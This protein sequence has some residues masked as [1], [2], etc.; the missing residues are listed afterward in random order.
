MWRVI[1]TDVLCHYGVRGQKRGHQEVPEPGRVIDLRRT[2]TV[3]SK[4]YP[5][6]ES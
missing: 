5:Y 4:K 1:E 6:K 2:E 3:C